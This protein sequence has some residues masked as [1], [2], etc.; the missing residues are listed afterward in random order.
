[1]IDLGDSVRTG[2]MVVPAVKMETTEFIRKSV[3][4]GQWL[5]SMDL[6]DTYFHVPISKESQHPLH[7]QIDSQTFQFKALPFGLATT[8]L[9]FTPVV[10]EV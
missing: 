1:M 7:F 3:T 2:Y 4:K 6:K 9:E 5:V 10:K 8:S